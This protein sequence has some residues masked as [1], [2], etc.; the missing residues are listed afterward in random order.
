MTAPVLSSVLPPRQ[1]MTLLW[2]GIALMAALVVGG[3]VFVSLVSR[4]GGDLEEKTL[5]TIASIAATSIEADAVRSLQGNEND[6]SSPAFAAVRDELK[7]IRQR[8]STARFVY[9]MGQ[10]DGA[11]FFLAD[12]ED[13]KSPDYSPPGQA[14]P[15]ASP[16]LLRVFSA[17]EA[18]VE[19][20][21][22]D[23]WGEWMSSLAP[24][25]DPKTQ[26]VLAVF[27]FDIPANHW[28]EQINLYRVFAGAI[29]G[30]L[31]LVFGIALFV[32][33][34]SQR[35][36]SHLN[37]QLKTE[38]D[39]LAKSNRIV[40]NSSTLLF[41]MTVGDQW[42]VTYVSRNIE[43][44]G[45]TAGE[46]LGPLQIWNLF[47]PDD[48]PHIRDDLEDLRAGKSNVARR[49]VRFRKGDNSWAWVDASMTGV[50][51]EIGC[52]I[53]GE[54][55]MFDIT[56]TR[57]AEDRIAYLA[58]HDGLTGLANRSAFM[59]RLQ[60]AFAETQRSGNPFAVLY[61]DIDH[62]KDINDAF[63]HEKGDLFLQMVAERLGAALRET[64]ALGRFSVARF[65]GD[66]FAVLETDVADPSDAAALAQRL[67]KTLALPF[68]IGE[69][70]IHATASIGISLFDK[71]IT[72]PNDLLVQAD[73]ALYRAKEAGRAQFHFHSCDLDIKVRERVAVAE[74]LHAALKN[75]ELELYYQPQVEIPSG[76]IIGLEALIRWNHPTRGLVPPS[77][78]IPIA[79]KSGLIVALGSWVIEEGC[80][81][82]EKWQAQELA[83][84]ILG[85]NLS[86]AQ[87]RNP[88]NLMREVES[89]LSR[90][91]LGRNVLE[92]ELTESVLI[93]TTEAHSDIL[94]RLRKLGVRIAIDDFGTGYS[95]LEYLHAYPVDRIKIAQQ[96][97]S[98]V[99]TDPG[100]AA[101]VK[102]TI[103]LADALKLEIIAEGVETVE[104]LTFLSK[105]GCQNI[106]GYYFSRP[107]PAAAA[108]KLLQRGKFDLP[109]AVAA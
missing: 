16:T 48:A 46:I 107:V 22:R 74:E 27:G 97:M 79:E 99:I 57:K 108:A 30:L 86:A 21:Y 52:L 67:I 72:D 34:R 103:G 75:G 24:I 63:G 28:R 92:F 45:H 91:K 65:G 101:I 17:G 19:R 78:F 60:L 105:A 20:P 26:K 81:Q 62:F 90:L 80:R 66:E 37:A 64:D 31:A 47:H 3:W 73:L 102:A 98:R 40:E 9:L 96:F 93:E 25:V 84:P 44:Y 11:V 109:L 29:V 77:Q 1:S 69:K 8:L 7:K 51:D 39:E 89:A 76:R 49:Q 18:M 88:P 12:A 68:S 2:I 43:R 70:N 58:S 82:L 55:M 13:P 83:V 54:G 4:A 5:V 61:L 85:I 100:D 23:R 10:R 32:Q 42:V 71:S 15:E 104:Q 95:S 6:L 41:R 106:Q 36:I 59:E 35:R 94:K 50:R 14:Y 53:G 38:L 87:F 56:D 33:A